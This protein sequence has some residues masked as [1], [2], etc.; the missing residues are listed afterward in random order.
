MI[1]VCNVSPSVQ[2]LPKL[3]SFLKKIKKKTQKFRVLHHLQPSSSNT[4][5]MLF[6]HLQIW[7]IQNNP[8]TLPSSHSYTTNLISQ[9]HSPTLI[10]SFFNLTTRTTLFSPFVSS[11]LHFY[12][13][14]FFFSTFLFSVGGRGDMGSNQEPSNLGFFSKLWSSTISNQDTQTTSSINIH[15]PIQTLKIHKTDI[16]REIDEQ[17]R[18]RPINQIWFKNPKRKTMGFHNRAE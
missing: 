1:S 8:L 3:N 14:P 13:F 9:F 4:F 11:S 2:F 7:K 16:R 12:T 10:S 5:I 18:T 6:N 15:F 17:N